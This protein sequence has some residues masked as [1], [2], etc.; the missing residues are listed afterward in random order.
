[1]AAAVAAVVPIWAV[2]AVV[3]IS[4]GAVAPASVVAVAPVSVAAGRSLVVHAWAVADS[5][6]LRRD[7]LAAPRSPAAAAL[8]LQAA[9]IGTAA[10]GTAAGTATVT[11]VSGQA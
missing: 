7:P 6:L 10:T 3:P 1:L 8:Q 9:T 2:A 11:A 4:A 5:Q